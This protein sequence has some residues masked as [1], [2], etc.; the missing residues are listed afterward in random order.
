MEEPTPVK[1]D[2]IASTISGQLKDTS[3]L[4]PLNMK[5]K[6]FDLRPAEQYWAQPTVKEF[7]KNDDKAFNTFYAEQSE[8]YKKTAANDNQLDIHTEASF[9]KWSA[10][11]LISY[12]TKSHSEDPWGRERFGD[13]YS[14]KKW[15]IREKAADRGVRLEEG[16]YVPI[17]QYKGD[18]M[19]AKN[20]DGSYMTD[21]EGRAYWKPVPDDY[22]LKSYDETYSPTAQ[23]MGIYGIDRSYVKELGHTFMKSIPNFLFRTADSLME[24]PR[25]M[26]ELGINVMGLSVDPKSISGVQ[27]KL[28]AMQQPISEASQQNFFDPVSVVSLGLDS[29]WQLLSMAGV[30][31][32][33]RALGASAET[34]SQAGRIYMT[35]MSTGQLAQ[36]SREH[37]LSPEETALLYGVNTLAIYKISKLS[38]MVTSGIRPLEF[39]AKAAETFSKLYGLTIAKKGFNESALKSFSNQVVNKMEGLISGMAAKPVVANA[40][41]EGMEEGVEQ[42]VD[43]GL[44]LAHD[45]VAPIIG[46]SGQFNWNA[47][48]EWDAM[49]QNIAGG[50]IG[51]S[52][53]HPLMKKMGMHERETVDSIENAVAVN[54]EGFLYKMADN[55]EKAGKMGKD[56]DDN[57]RN[58][59][60]FRKIIDTMVD[61][62]DSAGLKDV[63]TNNTRAAGVFSDILKSSSI[64]RDKIILGNEM[65]AIQMRMDNA[66]QGKAAPETIEKVQKEMDYKAKEIEYLNSG[67]QVNRYITEG[68]YNVESSKEFRGQNALHSSDHFNGK[69]FMVMNRDTMSHAP[70]LEERMKVHNDNLALNDTAATPLNYSQNPISEA[71][72]M[73]VVK[74]LTEV[75][76]P[77]LDKLKAQKDAID[78][79]FKYGG[80]D[81]VFPPDTGP[82]DSENLKEEISPLHHTPEEITAIQAQSWFKDLNDLFT[83]DEQIR[84]VTKHPVV[85]PLEKVTPDEWFIY[86]FED[87][88]STMPLYQRV[89]SE[90][91]NAGQGAKSRE[92]GEKKSSM[93]ISP[94]PAR[95]VQ[96]IED[97]I[98]QVKGI[99][100]LRNDLN[101]DKILVPDLH[102]PENTLKE[103]GHLKAIFQGLAKLSED[104][105]NNTEGRIM[106]VYMDSLATALDTIHTASRMLAGKSDLLVDTF[107]DFDLDM[108]TAIDTGDHVAFRKI[109][110][111]MEDRAF[112]MFGNSRNTILNSM[113][114]EGKPFDDEVIKAKKAYDYV[115]SILSHSPTEIQAAEYAFLDETPEGSLVATR[116]QQAIIDSAVKN[117]L[118]GNYAW[119]PEPQFTGTAARISLSFTSGIDGSSGTG[120]TKVVIP[121]IAHVMNHLTGGKVIVTAAQDT[122]GRKKQK[123]RADVEEF[124]KKKPDYIEYSQESK[125]LEVLKTPGIEDVTAIIFDEASLMSSAELSEINT[126]LNRI[127]ARRIGDSKIPLHLFYTYDAF[128]NG[129]RPGN[130]ARSL[131][132][133]SNRVN[134]PST[135]RM[136][137]SFRSVNAPLKAA[138]ELFRLTQ[139]SKI[140][141]KHVFEFDDDGNGV[142]VVKSREDLEKAFIKLAEKQKIKNGGITQVVYI[143]TNDKAPAVPSISQMGVENIT[144]IESQ[145]SEW[146][147]AV[148]DSSTGNPFSS[149]AD[150]QEFYTAITRPRKGVIIYLAPEVPIESVKGVVREFVPMKP[151]QLTKADMVSEMKDIGSGNTA[152]GLYSP[153]G[154]T[155]KQGSIEMPGE[156]PPAPSEPSVIITDV[157]AEEKKAYL[158]VVRKYR[159]P[160]DLVVMNTFFNTPT[161]RMELKK[162]MLHD[163]TTQKA[164]QYYV[165]VARIGSPGYE[166]ASTK[167]TPAYSKGDKYGIFIEGVT[168]KGEREI[169]G[170]LSKEY[171]PERERTT[172]MLTDSGI[173]SKTQGK[174]I[175]L[176]MP[177]SS[178][179]IRQA[180]EMRP[181]IQ[182]T[183]SKLGGGY[184]IDEKPHNYSQII[185]AAGKSAV[186]VSPVM[187][188]SEEIVSRHS[189]GEFLKPGYTFVALSY[190]YTANELR[191]LVNQGKLNLDDDAVTLLSVHRGRFELD[192]AIDILKPYFQRNS[193]GYYGLVEKSNPKH[194]EAMTIY[195]ALWYNESGKNNKE[196]GERSYRRVYDEVIARLQKEDP[197][198]NNF[199]T[200][201]LVH[202]PGGYKVINGKKVRIEAGYDPK[203]LFSDYIAGQME[204]NPDILSKMQY[205]AKS[206]IFQAM[207]DS[208][209][210][211][212]Q[213]KFSPAVNYKTTGTV[214]NPVPYFTIQTPPQDV[215]DDG[216]YANF[217]RIDGPKPMLPFALLTE[218]VATATID[219]DKA[220]V[221]ETP[222]E[223][224]LQKSKIR[225][226]P[227]KMAEFRRLHNLSFLQAKKA[228]D[229]LKRQVVNSHVL[230]T[231]P[232]GGSPRILNV[233]DVMPK[234]KAQY[235]SK[236]NAE[237]A[238]RNEQ[239][240]IDFS[241]G[242]SFERLLAE[243]FP[244]ISFDTMTGAYSMDN[245]VSKTDSFS[246]QDNQNLLT[247]GI[248][249]IVKT[250]LYATPLPNGKYLSNRHV[251]NLIPLFRGVD[252]KAGLNSVTV[253]SVQQ[254][255]A[256]LRSSPLPEAKALLE[257]YF[258][259]TPVEKGESQIFSTYQVDSE[260]GQGLTNAILD[261]FIKAQKYV[262]G[263]AEIQRKYRTVEGFPEW[264]AD[265][266]TSKHPTGAFPPS[267]MTGRF[268]DNFNTILSKAKLNTTKNGVSVNGREYVTSGQPTIS[269][270]VDLVRAMGRTGYTEDNM[271]AWMQSEPNAP[272][273]VQK[274]FEKSIKDFI[275]HDSPKPTPQMVSMLTSYAEQKGMGNDF[276]HQDAEGGRQNILRDASPIFHVHHYASAIRNGG[277]ADVLANNLLVDTSSPYQYSLR[278]EPFNNLGVRIRSKNGDRSKSLEK[279]SAS[280]LLDIY[281]LDGFVSPIVQDK[282][283]VSFPVT[284]YSDSG[285]EIAPVFHSKNWMDTP[286]TTLGRLFDSRVNYFIGLEQVVLAPYRTAGLIVSSAQDLERQLS[287]MTS[288]QNTALSQQIPLSQTAVAGLH[289]DESR[290][291]NGEIHLKNQLLMDLET[292]RNP[293]NKT[294]FIDN[295]KED[296]KS[297]IEISKQPTSAPQ[298]LYDK[299]KDLSKGHTPEQYIE[300]FYASWLTISTEFQ[301]M[302]NGPEY[303]YKKTGSD[304]FIDMVKRSRSLTSPASFFV[305]RNDSWSEDVK[306]FRDNNSGKPLPLRLLYEGA[307]LN[308]MSKIFVVSDP[309]YKGISLSSGNPTSQK[310]MDGATL[311][312]PLTRLKQD[313][314]TARTYGP[315]V[316][317]VMKNITHSFDRATG[318]K[319]FVKNAEF[320]ITPEIL[321]N[322]D[323]W[324]LDKF[325]RMVG[326]Q[327]LE[328]LSSLGVDTTTFHNVT[329]E[330]FDKLFTKLIEEGRQDE[331]V[332]ELIFQSSMKTGQ[333]AVNHVDAERYVPS[334]IDI[335]M[336]GIQQDA[337]HDP[338]QGLN[339]KVLTQLVQAISTNW[340]NDPVLKNFYNTLST[341][342]KTYLDG[343]SVMSEVDRERTFVSLMKDS[344]LRDDAVNYR[345]D[346]AAVNRISINDRMMSGKY[347]ET[348]ASEIKDMAVA[349]PLQ[350]GNYV[351]HPATFIPL[352]DVIDNET[353]KT[354]AVLRSQLQQLSGVMTQPKVTTPA[355]TTPPTEATNRY[356]VGEA[357]QLKYEDATREDGVGLVQLYEEANGL[358]AT[359]KTAY[360]AAIKA[361]HDSLQKD[362]WMKGH[363][364]IM[365]P[366]EMSREFMLSD[367]IKANLP[368]GAIDAMY[369]YNKLLSDKERVA[370]GVMSAKKMV[371]A[372]MMYESFQKRLSGIMARIPTSGKHSALSIHVA[373]FMN[374]SMN[375]VFVPPQLLTVQGADQDIDKGSY[376]TYKSI[377]QYA[378]VDPTV[379]K[380]AGITK[381]YDPDNVNHRHLKKVSSQSNYTGLIPFPTNLEKI[382]S[383]LPR[384][385]KK[386]WTAIERM[387]LENDLAQSLATIMDDPKTIVEA[388]TSTDDVLNPLRAQRDMILK[389]IENDP[390]KRL[391]FEKLESLLKSHEMA[392]AGGKGLTGIFANGAKAFSVLYI[393][394][395]IGSID[396]PVTRDAGKIWERYAGLIG[397]S[398]DNQ[399]ENILGTIGIDNTV[400]P[401]VSWWISQG[402]DTD[403]IKAAI[404]ENAEFFETLRQS[405]RYDRRS[406]FTLK[407]VPS[408]LEALYYNVA[409]WSILSNSLV[410]RNI[411]TRMEEV[412]S[413]ILSFENFVNYSYRDAGLPMDFDLENFADGEDADYKNTQVNKYN[414]LLSMADH[415]YN[416]L[417]VFRDAPHMREY[418]RALLATH[419]Q[420][421]SI[422]AY[423]LV[424]N[425]QRA[426]VDL[427]KAKQWYFYKKEAFNDDYDFVHGLFID[428]YLKS[429]NTK[430]VTE[431]DLA[432][433]TGRE[434]FIKEFHADLPS[435]VKTYSDN[436]LIGD[437][438]LET[439]EATKDSSVRLGDFF[440][441]N[442]DTRALYMQELD[443]LA[444]KDKKRL[445]LYNLITTRDKNSMGA[446]TSFFSLDDKADY[447]NFLDY[448]LQ[449]NT[450]DVTKVYSERKK[451]RNPKS[452]QAIPYTVAFEINPMPKLGR[453][454]TYKNVSLQTVKAIKNTSLNADPVSRGQVDGEWTIYV[455][456]TAV[457]RAFENK[458]WT[459][460]KQLSDGSY[461]PA[462][463]LHAFKTSDEFKSYLIEL[464]YLA[465]TSLETDQVATMNQALKNL[466]KQPTLKRKTEKK[467]IEDAN[468]CGL[469]TT[470]SGEALSHPR[471]GAS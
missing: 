68:L 101:Y 167:T 202:R 17:D 136:S 263:Y 169:L 378:M 175:L 361:I 197:I 452:E 318:T 155:A 259:S 91:T 113:L 419:Q 88:K 463:P 427:K 234:L 93:Y 376:L 184:D 326:P 272:S 157:G 139:N 460:P 239:S 266:R 209:T 293:A 112:N 284:V 138:E 95:L 295:I 398:V 438:S 164:T 78:P 154:V 76:Q 231:V 160:G 325:R 281:L 299:V 291:K 172:Q 355:Q 218:L 89:E 131:S 412:A 198:V 388:N 350:G 466:G 276:S 153:K 193:D 437:L 102:A 49:L 5:A 20:T 289:Y 416:I 11:P 236:N 92:E 22:E 420:A 25:Q 298:T 132:I 8:R 243:Y 379:T 369:F 328:D 9:D 125:L 253:R 414:Q 297:I 331:P 233:A 206:R 385:S 249:A 368:L 390:K 248:T 302:M 31:R 365:L 23:R 75:R 227:M 251:A 105:F 262:P 48:Q 192:K 244:A 445:F 316:G 279:M 18:V 1:P 205:A 288:E 285:T 12:S 386:E 129:A 100:R 470:V 407:G 375:S 436:Q 423:D 39:N 340:V 336:K 26:G 97:R 70:T 360:Q 447:I 400:A 50:A 135:P 417:R 110:L 448:E 87:G 348:I 146:D 422:K 3:S 156:P 174:D 84:K 255:E 338:S 144:S 241:L 145:G 149:T 252:F 21:A 392:Q 349:F 58:A 204:S 82:E 201:Q 439:N 364:E 106:K 441:M 334:Y 465:I 294:A 42:A 217:N 152:E 190:K 327:I 333:R 71:G 59:S 347:L 238:S 222:I 444:P 382:K 27:S 341:I 242:S 261:F 265:D 165:T 176:H 150:T 335:T 188:A 442:D 147:Y 32:A 394:D 61:I 247:N 142:N 267:A 181:F 225:V 393:A 51:G 410:N 119:N 178:D 440:D 359:D 53:M 319:A 161:G 115:R 72:K 16:K 317:P 320:E 459:K 186:A 199:I 429:R 246:E 270:S 133:S 19:M 337:M 114:I 2:W 128:Q 124:F 431:A 158:D 357:R 457:K 434:E 296:I 185:E 103:L 275:R 321:A 339:T 33:T 356:T 141:S 278:N 195:R 371:Q 35:G 467:N 30:A 191:Q 308:K 63:L 455:D 469:K 443:R 415:S 413:Y 456:P 435:L 397:A 324:I 7:F 283:E 230:L 307:K 41:L 300:R 332:D 216:L 66:V 245:E 166:N 408:H 257:R 6:D 380:G 464:Q 449:M 73:S 389:S 36:I 127:N 24:L 381:T 309:E 64:G 4:I 273:I 85:A 183:V 383:I 471:S 44:R 98:N 37:G 111:L 402:L 29:V 271:L 428:A 330:H 148:I 34:A 405:S 433:M 108:Q 370:T 122:G 461:P 168:E 81:Q 56:T 391:S 264:R 28:R 451:E 171:G 43:S 107:N 14:P 254:A 374:G 38:D 189:K 55:W 140:S 54:D 282:E 220:N 237:S 280:E 196:G 260:A 411:P 358:I 203:W 96:V 212:G 219:Q 200:S 362:N 277:V 345:S 426:S 99:Y 256:T 315:F 117:A 322:G 179:V 454:T 229:Q 177:I 432:T 232:K 45:T 342:T 425:M 384:M 323:E 170:T 351:V 258:S 224:G 310:Y 453:P 210:M 159:K 354:F 79:A 213:L 187:V 287:A 118:A 367:A 404:D 366:A 377:V 182:N 353:G 208:P 303:Q 305:L 94:E 173:L 163:E 421:R 121:G 90:L 418:Q 269:N 306:K 344:L 387:A 274:Y 134:V 104:N 401:Y 286:E 120:K 343:L 396:S 329:Y 346:A 215:M 109:K 214:A 137:F 399:N 446:V 352:F 60:A 57:R 403:Q 268:I 372:E 13:Y 52:V 409:E 126:E 69:Y 62:R 123:V 250:Y 424:Y 207:L 235:L 74:Q 162:A 313:Y 194:D 40:F 363:A 143:R 15:G 67:S 304:S 450:E 223:E 65:N 83:V 314:S 116:E 311:V 211:K 46:M 395:K 240:K 292:Y 151:A 468:K 221:S 462:I 80:I 47:G 301:K 226:T 290:I 458:V 180:E 130:S 430:S 406:G 228:I 373:A 86:D 312:T 10:R 77:I